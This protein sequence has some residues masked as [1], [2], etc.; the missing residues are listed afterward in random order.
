MIKAITSKLAHKQCS[1]LFI[2]TLKNIG[3]FARVHTIRVTSNCKCMQ[4]NCKKFF[5]NIK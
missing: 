2:Q 1:D 3:V 4:F 5:Q